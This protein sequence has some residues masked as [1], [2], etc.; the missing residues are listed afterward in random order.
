[1]IFFKRG[2]VALSEILN[3]LILGS[4]WISFNHLFGCPFPRAEQQSSHWDQH[5]SCQV[6]APG[7]ALAAARHPQ[8]T[9]WWAVDIELHLWCYI[10]GSSTAPPSGMHCWHTWATYPSDVLKT[11][12]FKCLNFW[13]LVVKNVLS[14]REWSFY[15]HRFPQLEGNVRSSRRRC[16]KS[17]KK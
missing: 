8:R 6:W 13:C 1:M 11:H 2:S 7:T 10:F 16:R 3:M 4:V 5:S 14:L 15:S 9:V 12:L 17:D